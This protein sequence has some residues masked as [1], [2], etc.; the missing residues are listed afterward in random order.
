FAG[1]PGSVCPAGPGG[2]TGGG[3]YILVRN[4]ANAPGQQNWRWCSKC[5]GLYFAGNPGSVCPAGP[6]GHTAGGNYT[7]EQDIGPLI[8]NV[9]PGYNGQDNWRWCSKCH[10][11]FFA[12]N[13]GSVCPAGPGGH[14]KTG[15]GNY[16]LYKARFNPVQGDWHKCSKCRVLFYGGDPGSKCPKGNGVH[17]K[18]GSKQYYI[19]IDTIEYPGNSEFRRCDK[20]KALGGLDRLLLNVQWA[21]E[22]IAKAKQAMFITWCHITALR[23]SHFQLQ[24]KVDGQYVKNACHYTMLRNFR[25]QLNVFPRG[26]NIPLSLV[27]THF[28]C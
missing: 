22:G 13:P 27:M 15:S 20:C 12:G 7:L 23:R 28:A 19:T 25:K 8:D 5:E 4:T 2:H 14:S 11:L 16:I 3:N 17:D 21:A 1:N 10:G 26:A 18:T 9:G 6:G 24:I